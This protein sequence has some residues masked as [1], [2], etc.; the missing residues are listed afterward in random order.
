MV[1]RD[2]RGWGKYNI[3]P[4]IPKGQVNISTTYPGVIRAFHM[5]LKQT[6]NWY[7]IDG[8]FEIV[9]VDDTTGHKEVLYVSGPAEKIIEIPP[10][11]WHGFRVLGN[12]SGVLL[13]YVTNKYDPVDP[14]EPRTPWNRFHSWETEY[15]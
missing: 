5:H 10:R 15:K 12:K 9:L 2:T 7:I 14:D 11:M 4:E 3:F 13:Y 8:D 1:F 6:D